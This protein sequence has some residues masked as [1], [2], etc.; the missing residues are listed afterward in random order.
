MGQGRRKRQPA[1]SGA[2]ALHAPRSRARRTLT[3]PSSC[4]VLWTIVAAAV[5]GAI[6][7]L[8]GA[9]LVSLGEQGCDASPGR[10][11]CGGTGV[12]LVIGVTAGCML[13]GA[14]ILGALG[15]PDAV[16]VSFFGVAA[17]LMVILW[18]LL[19]HVFSAWMLLVVPLMTAVT[20]VLS[21]L[22]TRALGDRSGTGRP[23]GGSG[24]D[25]PRDGPDGPDGPTGHEA[26]R[27]LQP[28][29]ASVSS[30][31]APS[32]PDAAPRAAEPRSAAPRHVGPSNEV[33]PP[34]LPRR[35]AAV[36]PWPTEHTDPTALTVPRSE[37]PVSRPQHASSAPPP[38]PPRAAAGRPRHAAP[39]SS[40]ATYSP[41]SS[42]PKHAAPTA[43]NDAVAV[44]PEQKGIPQQPRHSSDER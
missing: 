23:T 1:H 24:R 17:A 27:H 7:G 30:S 12:I 22:V 40:R 9:L 42:R 44:R 39:V 31:S 37:A 26:T 38:I 2:T 4:T 19:G 15:V 3:A 11:S 35:R 10:A 43:R 18:F 21:G 8:V 13:L 28:V 25:D 14:L 33:V 20:F 36:A 5:T 32:I 34:V 6:C 16:L 29:L 41:P